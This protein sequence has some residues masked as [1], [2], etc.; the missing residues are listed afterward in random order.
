MDVRR[1]RGRVYTVASQEFHELL[2]QG[3]PRVITV[4]GPYH[5]R[6]CL[7]VGV[8]EGGEAGDEAPNVRWGFMFVAHYVNRFETRVVI[9][10]Y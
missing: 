10:E 8:E 2:G 1:A 4:S 5:T 9:H 3:L 6:R 7:S